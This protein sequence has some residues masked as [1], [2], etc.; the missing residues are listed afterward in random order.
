MKQVLEKLIRH[1]SFE[2]GG[3]SAEELVAQWLKDYEAGWVRL[4][5]IEA[6]YQGRYKAIS[7]EQILHFWSR[8]GRPTFH[9]NHD[10]ERLISGKPPQ[11]FGKLP[12]SSHQNHRLL[13]PSGSGGTSQSVELLTSVETSPL[14]AH[15]KTAEPAASA[16]LENNNGSVST[17]GMA[18]EFA[19]LTFPDFNHSA[20]QASPLQTSQ[21]QY[22]SESAM[23]SEEEV[24]NPFSKVELERH[25]PAY[26]R[27]G[28]NSEVEHS[29]IHEFTP[30]PEVSEFYLK[31]KAVAK[32]DAKT[33]E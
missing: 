12:D 32:Q 15:R 31:L 1:Y 3:H 17:Q 6:L 14:S 24:T 5:V 21:P 28:L 7:I 13:R 16:D 11:D 2:T 27:N 9:F 30:P 33:S 19:P 4:A 10:F 25:S 22:S 20:Q 23:E 29:P 26:E 8:R 18:S